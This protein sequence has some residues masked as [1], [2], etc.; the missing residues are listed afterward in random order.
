MAGIH[1]E[2]KLKQMGAS[3]K[4][5]MHNKTSVGKVTSEDM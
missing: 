3:I 1:M 5:P 4:L 2:V